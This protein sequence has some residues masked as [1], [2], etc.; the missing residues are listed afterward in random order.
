MLVS[1]DQFKELVA[2]IDAGLRALP[3]TAQVRYHSGVLRA[4]LATVC[5]H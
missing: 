3:A 4:L 2:K 5:A 1:K